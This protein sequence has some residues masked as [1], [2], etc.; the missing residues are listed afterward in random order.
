MFFSS[1]K[2][3]YS[4]QKLK[5]ILSVKSVPLKLGCFAYSLRRQDVAYEEI[6]RDLENIILF[7]IVWHS[8]TVTM[9]AA[10]YSIHGAELFCEFGKGR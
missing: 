4:F 1:N 8:G 3:F 6:I 9:C 10:K 5:L 7:Y 2:C